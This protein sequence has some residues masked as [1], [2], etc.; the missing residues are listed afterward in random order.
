MMKQLGS[1]MNTIIFK[2]LIVF[3][4]SSPKYDSQKRFRLPVKMWFVALLDKSDSLFDQSL[5]LATAVFYALAGTKEPSK[6]NDTSSVCVKSEND[7]E[8]VFRTDLLSGEEHQTK[9]VAR[10]LSKHKT[11]WHCQPATDRC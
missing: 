2:L 8:T 10:Q 11:T 7:G 4:F 1:D 6:C 9:R 3:R 5:T